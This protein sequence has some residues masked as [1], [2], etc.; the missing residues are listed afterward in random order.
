MT[1]TSE[2]I[3]NRSLSQSY[4]QPPA[5]GFT[6][7]EMLVVLAILGIL[8]LVAFPSYQDSVRRTRRADGIAAVLAIQAAQE[9]FRANCPFYAQNLGT[10]SICGAESAASTVRA[11]ST[12]SDGFYSLSIAPDSASGNGYTI[13]A[14]AQG[15][16]TSDTSCDPLSAAY[17]AMHPSGL[18]TP[19]EC[20]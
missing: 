6:L 18:R 3:Y 17:D 1:A 15:T 19:A 9:G 14:V 13:L 5:R 16:Q 20:W 10:S 12:S 8:A 4:M 2:A 7:L 11:P